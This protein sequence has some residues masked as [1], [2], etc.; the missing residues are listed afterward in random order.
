MGSLRGRLFVYLIGGTALAL[1][2][3]GFVL[4]PIV[5]DTLQREFDRALLAKA[6]GL[7]ALTEQEGDQ[8]EFEFQ[9]EHMPEFAAGAEPE[10][11]ELWLADGS[12]VQRSPS[13]DA[14]DQM[15]A[16][17]LA[18]SPHPATT[19]SHSGCS[20]PR[21]APGTPGP[22]RFRAVHRSRGCAGRRQPRPRSVEPLGRDPARGARARAARR[23]HPPARDDGRGRGHRSDARARWPHAACPAGR[24]SLPGPADGSGARARRGLPGCARRCD[25]AA[26]RRSRWSSSR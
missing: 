24:P 26:A 8:V 21:R 2:V 5:A 3:A 12:L 13:F 17:S 1:L 10:Y 20:P 25:E 14:S 18:R 15:R 7:V 23:R 4:R 16:A 6:R 11:F 19:P 9:E 22:D